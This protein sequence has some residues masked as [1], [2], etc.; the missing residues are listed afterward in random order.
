MISEQSDPGDLTLP[1]LLIGCYTVNVL[2]WLEG[3]GDLA[4]LRRSRDYARVHRP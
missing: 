4:L 1:L 2:L 3:G